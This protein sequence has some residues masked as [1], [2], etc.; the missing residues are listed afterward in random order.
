[1]HR[2][3]RLSRSRDFDA[4]YRSGRSASTRFLV[5]YWFPR[6]E[7]DA[8]APRLGLAVPK[9]VGNAVVRNRVKR[10]LRETWTELADRARPGHDYVLVVRPG[11]AEPAD[12]RGH[13]W[14][15]E[16]VTEVLEKAAA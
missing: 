10:Q 11:L 8:D 15:A 1:M 12:T 9:S 13:E 7:G 16:R 4:V 2:R 5:L 6:E 3:N 14:L